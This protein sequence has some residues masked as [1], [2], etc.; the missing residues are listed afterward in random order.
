MTRDI[1]KNK[2]FSMKSY[3]CLLTIRVW[4]FL[5]FFQASIFCAPLD[6]SSY[7]LMDKLFP[8]V[9]IWTNGGGFQ[10]GKLPYKRFSFDCLSTLC[11]FQCLGSFSFYCKQIRHLHTNHFI[12]VTLALPLSTWHLGPVSCWEHK[13]ILHKN[14]I[15][16][17]LIICSNLPI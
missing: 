5:V 7:F 12:S 6:P 14:R 8:S 1:L 9:G 4:S 3:F 17:L 2:Q 15:F 10:V 11:L 16:L 13:F